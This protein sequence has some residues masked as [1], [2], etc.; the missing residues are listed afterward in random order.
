MLSATRRIKSKFVRYTHSHPNL[1][2]LYCCS[3]PPSPSTLLFQLHQ[4]T[5]PS[6]PAKC[7]CTWALAWPILS[8]WTTLINLSVHLKRHFLCEAF[9]HPWPQAEL[10]LSCAPTAA[11]TRALRWAGK[12]KRTH[13]DVGLYVHV[14]IGKSWLSYLALAHAILCAHIYHSKK[15]IVSSHLLSQRAAHFHTSSHF[16]SPSEVGMIFPNYKRQNREN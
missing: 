10:N 6:Q 2:P 3:P 11:K 8:A 12:L 15:A 4:N 13:F 16:S 9:P 1:I 7:L 14:L 5:H